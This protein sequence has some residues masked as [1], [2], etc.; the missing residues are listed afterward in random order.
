MAEAISAFRISSYYCIKVRCCCFFK[1]F[2]C[3]YGRYVFSPILFSCMIFAEIIFCPS[4]NLEQPVMVLVLFLTYQLSCAMRYLIL[5]VSLSLLVLK[6]N[7]GPHSVQRPFFSINI[8]LNIV[9]LV[10]YLYILCIL[11]VN[12]MPGRY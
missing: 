1:G 8:S 11:A 10:M 9:Y 3:L 7:Q 2:S 12:V 4:I 6:E 5:S